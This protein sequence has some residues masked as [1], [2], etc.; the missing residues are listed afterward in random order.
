MT[1]FVDLTEQTCHSSVTEKFCKQFNMHNLQSVKYILIYK[2]KKVLLLPNNHFL[3]KTSL[4]LI[5]KSLYASY[6]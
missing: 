6:E 4:C 2:Q 5:R 3:H 1:L